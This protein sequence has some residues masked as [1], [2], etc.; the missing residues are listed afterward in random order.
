MT[1]QSSDS[2]INYFHSRIRFAIKLY[3]VKNLWSGRLLLLCD[4]TASGC[5]CP[6]L[7]SLENTNRYRWYLCRGS[8]MYWRFDY[9][10]Q[11]FDV[12]IKLDHVNSYI[13]RREREGDF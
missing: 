5:K 9:K 11:V 4:M 6:R 12:G 10:E 3:P 1:E 7:N 13:R 8:N 2:N